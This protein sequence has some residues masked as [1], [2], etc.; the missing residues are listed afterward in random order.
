[1]WWMGSSDTLW[2]ELYHPKKEANAGF[3]ESEN[4]IM[5]SLSLIC[6]PEVSKAALNK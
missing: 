4:M 5:Q 1:M 2:L 6:F 3:E